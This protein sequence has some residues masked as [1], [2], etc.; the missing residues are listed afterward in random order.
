MQ[1]L[2]PLRRRLEKQRVLGFQF[3]TP[4][5]KLTHGPVCVMFHPKVHKIECQQCKEI[6]SCDAPRGTCNVDVRTSCFAEGVE[7]R[8]EDV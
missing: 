8:L 1:F 4:S 5:G 6:I 2:F 7:E 3:Q